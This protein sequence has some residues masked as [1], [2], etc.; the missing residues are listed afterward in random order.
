MVP[1]PQPASFALI[2][3]CCCC[4][5]CYFVFLFLFPLAGIEDRV[6]RY[7]MAEDKVFRQN[8][9][10]V[11]TTILC[12]LPSQGSQTSCTPIWTREKKAQLDPRDCIVGS[13]SS[14]ALKN[15][16]LLLGF[17]EKGVFMHLGW[18]PSFLAEGLCGK[19]RNVGR[20]FIYILRG[21]SL[22]GSRYLI[23]SNKE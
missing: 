2:L 5:C 21:C 18:S 14:T 16:F 15:W 23:K 11:Q 13:R 7:Q 20:Y 12:L 9:Q 22:S 8:S 6:K 10:L 3:L 4:C 19:Y 17:R 1:L